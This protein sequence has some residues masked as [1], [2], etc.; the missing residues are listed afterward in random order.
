MT[1]IED[2]EKIEIRIG[3]IVKCV[4]FAK[5]KK[6]AFQLWVDLGEGL[7]LKQSSA[8]LTKNYHPEAL[9]GSQVVC[10][11]NLPPRKIADFVSEVLVT[12]F[13]DENGNVVLCTAR[14]TVPN[15]AKLY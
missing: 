4:P 7:G 9:I 3:T 8:Q 6:P 1:T 13:A 15:G 5:A 10:V 2:F 12:G 14:A 11:V